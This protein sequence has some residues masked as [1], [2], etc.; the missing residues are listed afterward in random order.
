MGVQKGV[1]AAVPGQARYLTFLLNAGT[2]PRRALSAL[3]KIADGETCVVGIGQSTVAACGAGIDGLREFPGFSGKGF[4]VPSTP[5]ALW[6]WLR[7]GD[8]GELVHLSRR[9]EAALAPAFAAGS[10]VDAFRHGS[11][12]D[13]TGYEDGTENPKG[14]KAVAAAVAKGS[15]AGPD[16]SSF[17]AVQ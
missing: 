8:R 13:L 12:R 4:T 7:G 3:A 17:V 10:V 5:A 16:G 2:H 11:G 14:R 9:I 15:C 1:L 6:C